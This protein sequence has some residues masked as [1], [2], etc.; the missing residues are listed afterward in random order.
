MAEG[1]HRAE[2]FEFSLARNTAVFVCGRVK[3][4]A[5]I[6]CVSHDKN[7]DWQ[8]LC[9]GQH[10]GGTEDGPALVCLE[11]V[12][13]RDSTLNELA[14]LCQNWSAERDAVG[15]P[16]RRHDHSED[17]INETV[18]RHGWVVELIR[19]E[20]DLPAFAYT[21]GLHRTFGG[22][23][24]IVLG[25][26]TEVMHRILNNCGERMRAGEK[27]PVGTPFAGIVDGY[28][29][30]LRPVTS[31]ESY[32]EYMGYGLWFYEGPN[33]PLLQLVWPD[34]AGRF[35]GEEGADPMMK[36]QQPLLP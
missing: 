5:P 8:F 3:A 9:G 23:E 33:F 31:L 35:P 26:R 28:D 20:G 22:P 16:W 13:A 1:G 29:V 25:L 10:G 2:R 6:L 4:G 17:F 34:Q 11:D 36:T 12:V 19:E 21:I 18:K 30:L 27:L 15:A 32:R 14:A 24:L 7:G